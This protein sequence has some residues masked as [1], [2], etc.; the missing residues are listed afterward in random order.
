MTEQ[1]MTLAAVY[2]IL[3]F[4]VTRAFSG[5][6]SASSTPAVQ[7]EA[8]ID[9]S[10]DDLAP[11]PCTWNTCE[12]PDVE[13]GAPFGSGNTGCDGIGCGTPGTGGAPGPGGGQGIM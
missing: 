10:S 9:A 5:C 7:T 3:G 12:R 4:E 11:T 1:R 8:G 6:S 2:L 13:A